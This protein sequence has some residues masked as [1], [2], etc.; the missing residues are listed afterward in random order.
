M[1]GPHFRDYHLLLDEQGEQIFATTDVIAERVRKIGGTTLHS[2]GHIGRSQ[3]V[4]DNDADFVTPDGYACRIA[5]RQQAA[6]DTPAA[7]RIAFAMSTTMLR[8]RPCASFTVNCSRFS[9]LAIFS[10]PITGLIQASCAVVRW[11][12]RARVIGK[13]YTR[14][15][16]VSEQELDAFI[17]FT[18]ETSPPRTDSTEEAH[19]LLIAKGI[20]TAYGELAPE[21][22]A[23][24]DSGKLHD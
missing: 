4:A 21:Y 10:K 14:S 9:R 6:G 23:T 11:R 7:R 2:I 13:G 1:S 12:R 8:P 22:R 18:L 3:R 15:G 19:A 20:I 5:R 24:G 16:V 17:C